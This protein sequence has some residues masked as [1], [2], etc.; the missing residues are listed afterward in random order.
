MRSDAAPALANTAVT[1]GSYINTNL[2]VDAQGRIT[3]AANGTAG[4]GGVTSITAGTGLTGGTITT[5]GTI[6][7]STPV[8][9][10]NGGTGSSNLTAFN[11]LAGN[12][13]AAVNLVPPGGNGTILSSLGSASLPNFRTLTTLLDLLAGTGS[14]G[15]IIY[16]GSAVWT[17]LASGT[18]GQVLQ[19]GGTSANPSWATVATPPAAANPTATVSGT[20]VNGS[21]TTY[22]RSD[23]APALANTAVTPGSYTNSSI[24][25]D[26]QGRLTAAASGSS[27]AVTISDTAPSP[28]AGMLWFDSAGGHL[29]L[30]YTD[31]NTSQWIVIL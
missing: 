6:S 21:A 1:P 5:T 29:Y 2:T 24:T 20:A 18:A 16:R 17:V 14:Q 11:V 25:V 26:A 7:L 23:A 31:P 4:G 13:A 3:T 12:G 30:Y 27:A 22:M 9:V 8:T 19:S 15:Q 10:A 28:T